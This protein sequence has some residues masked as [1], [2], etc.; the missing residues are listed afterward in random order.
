M[1]HTLQAG[2][3]AL[4]AGTLWQPGASQPGLGLDPTANGVAWRGSGQAAP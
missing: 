1:R 4:A 3:V 2:Y